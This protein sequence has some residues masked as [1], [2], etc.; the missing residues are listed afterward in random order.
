MLRLLE[1]RD[2]WCK[3]SSGD[4]M[5]WVS[6][7]TVSPRKPIAK[8]TVLDEKSPDIGPGARRRASLATSAGATRGFTPEGRQRADEG[9]LADHEALKK[10]ESLQVSEEE[11][12]DFLAEEL[13]P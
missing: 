12:L 4:N 7:L 9:G 2:R 8:V 11:A 13:N 3:I 10:M 1:V 5:G 6:T